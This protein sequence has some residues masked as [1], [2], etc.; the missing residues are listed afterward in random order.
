MPTGPTEPPGPPVPPV[1]A[2]TVFCVSCDVG[3]ATETTTSSVE[4]WVVVFCAVVKTRALGNARPTVLM[5]VGK[6]V[7]FQRQLH[8]FAQRHLPA[9]VQRLLWKAVE[10]LPWPRLRSC[11][12]VA[13]ASIAAGST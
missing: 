4:P 6:R 8:R 10:V 11:C 7:S 5:C 2:F 9:C 3:S 12:N 1:P 13:A